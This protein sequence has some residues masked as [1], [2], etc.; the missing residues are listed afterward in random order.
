MGRLNAMT[1]GVSN[2][3]VTVM[4]SAVHKSK[5]NGKKEEGAY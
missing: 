4:M 5:R 1:Q 2:C 3:L